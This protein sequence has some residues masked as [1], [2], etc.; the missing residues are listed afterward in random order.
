MSKGLLLSLLASIMVFVLAISYR[1]R[2]PSFEIK[3]YEFF[4]ALLPLLLYGLLSG[5]I[6]R[7]EFFGLKFESKF[8]NAVRTRIT[9]K[10]ILAIN[11]IKATKRIPTDEEGHLSVLRKRPNALEFILTDED[12]TKESIETKYPICPW[13]DVLSKSPTFKYV[14]FRDSSGNFKAF[15]LASSIAA[16]FTSPAGKCEAIQLIVWIIRSIKRKMSE[17]EISNKLPG[18]IWSGQAASL[19]WEKRHCLKKMQD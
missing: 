2:N 19:G 3:N 13:L 6:R 11:S 17:S 10:D 14:I 5:Q 1:I 9:K 16:M 7:L 12:D 4:I 8:R 15:A 18:F